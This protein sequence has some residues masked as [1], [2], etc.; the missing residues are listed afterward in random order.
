MSSTYFF[1]RAATLSGSAIGPAGFGASKVPSASH[2][3]C[4]RVSICA[5]SSAVYRY[6]GSPSSRWRSGRAVSVIGGPLLVS[7]C[8]GHE[9]AP[10]TGGAAALTSCRG[11]ARPD[12]EQSVTH[13]INRTRLARRAHPG[14]GGR[15]LASQPGPAR[16]PVG[17]RDLL[18]RLAA[19]PTIPPSAGVAPMVAPAIFQMPR[20][21]VAAYRS[22]LGST[23]RSVTTVSGRPAPSRY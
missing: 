3:S 5:A 8:P 6:G 9:K 16:L 10:R 4:H 21:Y 13:A 11:S 2:R 19:V 1:G 15:G 17:Q 22:P 18:A 14:T 7:A 20:P 12:K 23:S